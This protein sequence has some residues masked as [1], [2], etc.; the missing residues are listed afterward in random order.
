M[1]TTSTTC[2][3]NATSATRKGGRPPALPDFFDAVIEDGH[4]NE[5]DALEEITER[6]DGHSDGHVV[7]RDGRKFVIDGELYTRDALRRGFGRRCRWW[8]EKLG[9]AAHRIPRKSGRNR[10][11]GVLP[12]LSR[13]RGAGAA[14]TPPTT[15]KAGPEAKTATTGGN[16]VA[17]TANT[18]NSGT[19]TPTRELQAQRRI[20]AS[21]GI[22]QATFRHEQF[23][24]RAQ[25]PDGVLAFVSIAV[26]KDH[27]EDFMDLWPLI[28]SDLHRELKAIDA[29]AVVGQDW[30]ARAGAHI[31]FVYA[32]PTHG[33]AITERILRDRLQHLLR[34]M[35]AVTDPR[36]PYLNPDGA[37]PLG[38][39]LFAEGANRVF[40]WAV[41][42]VTKGDVKRT[43]Q[44]CLKSAFTRG[45]SVLGVVPTDTAHQL[46]LGG[47]FTG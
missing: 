41:C 24:A 15:P 17:P 7:S 23:L 27:A 20:E 42:T 9:R 39:R 36:D 12:A 18:K 14:R 38:P 43:V 34:R 10:R 29:I 37:P 31:H 13:S 16:P 30:E 47:R 22:P 44:Y 28:A 3:P 25:Q 35:R 8:R 6:Y 19:K 40:D 46:Q 33:R 2:T 11:T 4:V 32:S 26:G 45:G 21:T 5:L 1:E